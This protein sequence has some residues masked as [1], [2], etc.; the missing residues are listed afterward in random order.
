MDS[1][2]RGLSR[3]ENNS[4]VV[5]IKHYDMQA[6]WNLAT[7]IASCH[8]ANKDQKVFVDYLDRKRILCVGQGV[9]RARRAK[10]KTKPI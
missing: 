5:P 9:K 2:T 8:I 1:T 3:S 4:N 6:Y 10:R 7:Q